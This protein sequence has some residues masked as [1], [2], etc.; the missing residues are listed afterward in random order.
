[1]LP[2]NTQVECVQSQIRVGLF[3]GLIPPFMYIFLNFLQIVKNFS[4]SM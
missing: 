1:M 2:T 3:V 4:V